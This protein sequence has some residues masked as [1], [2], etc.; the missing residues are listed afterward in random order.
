MSTVPSSARTDASA[1]AIALAVAALG[2][3]AL[4]APKFVLSAGPPCLI[5][6]LFG[7]VCWG[8]GITRA[9]LSFLH[10]DLA[11]A[12]GHN[13]LSLIVM[14]MLLWLYFQLL[15]KLWAN[16]ARRAAAS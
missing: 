2:A 5:S 7:D 10:G 12:W 1:I 3:A 6:A 4:L 14:P 15:R 13:R 16:H 8:C 11:A 9:A